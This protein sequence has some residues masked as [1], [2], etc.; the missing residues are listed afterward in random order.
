[1]KAFRIRTGRLSCL[2]LVSAGVFL[3]GCASGP[4]PQ[5]ARDVRLFSNNVRDLAKIIDAQFDLA[6]LANRR[7]LQA[8]INLQFD[9]GG[10]PKVVLPLLFSSEIRQ[11]RRV[12]L[13]NLRRYADGLV[14]AYSIEEQSDVQPAPVSIPVSLQSVSLSA[15]P[16]LGALAAAGP[17]QAARLI[18]SL[19]GLSALVF[20]PRRDRELAKIT[21][22]LHPYIVRMVAL[23][24]LDLGEAEDKKTSCKSVLPAI[25]G[26]ETI[27]ELRLCRGGVRFLMMQA[28]GSLVI[29]GNAR[30]QLTGSL[31]QMKRSARADIINH[32]YATEQAGRLLEQMM[33][34]TQ[35]ALIMLVAAHEALVNSFARKYGFSWTALR[36]MRDQ[37]PGG[38]TA[39][40]VQQVTRL[41]RQLVDI[42]SY[43]KLQLSEDIYGN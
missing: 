31:P 21:A 27:L 29:S 30:L 14:S 5:L 43:F 22:Q 34:E 6:E 4:D 41:R 39:N 16:D 40:L 17:E 12:L 38:V 24:F 36:L 23:L 25:S 18:R 1:M 8:N 32:I 37:Q 9:L 28:I 42:Q 3:S 2:L 19:N 11:V 15:A 7:A 10:R 26:K 13:D 20:Y 35:R 33:R